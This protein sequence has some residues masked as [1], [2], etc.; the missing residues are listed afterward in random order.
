MTNTVNIS[1]ES[2]DLSENKE[3]GVTVVGLALP[4]NK[5]SRNGFTYVT[6]S[7]KENFSS[8][9]GAPVLFNHN[10]ENV[11]GHVKGASLSGSGLMYEMDLDPSEPITAKLKRGDLKK[12]SI[13]C[14]YDGDKSF[15]NEEG[16]TNAYIKEFL[17]LSVVSIPGFADTTAQVVESFKSEKQSKSNE[18]KM[19]EDEK[20]DAPEEKNTSEEMEDRIVKLEEAIAKCMAYIE[21]QKKA[22]QEEDEDEEK[23]A[24]ADE[25]PEKDPEEEVKEAEDTEEDEKKVEEARKKDKQTVVETLAPKRE[26]TLTDKDLKEL[27]KSM[28]K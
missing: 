22:E 25:E 26:I 28:R 14:I 17:E 18:E 11:I 20:K 15:I 10:S 9:I 19:P 27:Y 6:E 16:I 5:I 1:V 24:E 8:L 7:I 12:V 3:G 21:D 4:F 23:S 2:Y 13:Q